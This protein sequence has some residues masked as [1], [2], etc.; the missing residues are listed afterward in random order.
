MEGEWV[1]ATPNMQG[2]PHEIFSTLGLN[3][4]RGKAAQVTGDGSKE[5]KE[6]LAPLRNMLS[7]EEVFLGASSWVSIRSEANMR[8]LKKWTEVSTSQLEWLKTEEGEKEALALEKKKARQ[9]GNAGEEQREGDNDEVDEEEI[10][11]KRLSR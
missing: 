1:Q 10:E 6:L 11:R 7:K 5:E 3:T 8:E 9:E 2:K 4:A